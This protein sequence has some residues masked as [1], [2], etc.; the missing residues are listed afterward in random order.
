MLACDLVRLCSIRKGA[1]EMWKVIS[2][3]KWFLI[4][5]EKDFPRQKLE[6]KVCLYYSPNV[7]AINLACGVNILANILND[8]FFK[9]SRQ[10]LPEPCLWDFL[11]Q[12]FQMIVILHHA[13]HFLNRMRLL[14]VIFFN[15]ESIK[16][17]TKHYLP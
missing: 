9:I 13:D 10:P 11:S 15:F 1:D 17:N 14:L 6:S 16:Q 2:V 5:A 4:S 8:E 12:C 3:R 7:F